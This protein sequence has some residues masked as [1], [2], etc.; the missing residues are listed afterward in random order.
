M[1]YLHL[2]QV[3][4]KKQKILQVM[5]W[6]Q[7]P[8]KQLTIIDVIDAFSDDPISIGD[9]LSILGFGKDETSKTFSKSLLDSKV[10][11]SSFLKFLQDNAAKLPGATD[12]PAQNISDK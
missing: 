1:H 7:L 11:G 5:Q 2:M 6:R 10:Y 12:I 4:S 3:K 9:R 8:M